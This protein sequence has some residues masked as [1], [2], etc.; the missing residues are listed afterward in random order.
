MRS[1]CH[2]TTTVSAVLA[3][4]TVWVGTGKTGWAEA[5]IEVEDWFLKHPCHYFSFELDESEDACVPVHG[6]S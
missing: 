3:E 5:R 4:I 1:C 2:I 6:L